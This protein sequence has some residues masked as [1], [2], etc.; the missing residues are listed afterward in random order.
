LCNEYR[1]TL[2]ALSKKKWHNIS[3]FMMLKEKTILVTGAG[4]GIGYACVAFCL[5]QGANVV[6]VTRNTADVQKL[7]TDFKNKKILALAGDVSKRDL[8][9]SVLE[10]SIKKFG[11]IDGLI[12][13]AGMRQRLDFF[14]IND[15]EWNQVIQNNL[16]NC[17]ICMQI[18]GKHMVSTGGGS[19]VNLSSVA[20]AQGLP[21]LS[22]YVASK[23]GIIGLSKS[24]A[25]ELA[26]QKVR[27]N[28]VC[29]G[30]IE[31][32]F[33]DDFKKNRE[34]LYRFTLER[35]PMGRWGE[36]HEIAGVAAFLLSDLS[37]YMTGAIVPVDGGWLAW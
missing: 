37:S 26:S 23:A 2:K 3:V 1:G 5:E 28:V 30:F 9:E 6:A 7:Q 8:V 12:N 29:P 20:G 33:A 22:G 4:K 25:L 18:I 34:N 35:T 31:T 32:S 21:Q 10:Q 19:I 13:N 27:V 15:S 24:V 16:Y 36:S 17:F 11:K 14:E